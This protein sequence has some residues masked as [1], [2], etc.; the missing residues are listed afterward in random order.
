MR[1]KRASTFV[2]IDEIRTAQR[3]Y[4]PSLDHI[5]V[6]YDVVAAEEAWSELAVAALVGPGGRSVNSPK[7][8]DRSESLLFGDGD[9][10][11]DAPE[12]DDPETLR[13]L[14]R[15]LLTERQ[16]R[17]LDTFRRIDADG[18]GRV[19]LDQLMQALRSLGLHAARGALAELFDVTDSTSPARSIEGGSFKK[20]SPAGGRPR[21]TSEAM[22]P[23]RE[24]GAIE[25]PDLQ[26]AVWRKNRPSQAGSPPSRERQFSSSQSST[27]L[28]Q[29][30]SANRSPSARGFGLAS[31]PL[32]PAAA[33]TSSKPTYSSPLARSQQPEPPPPPEDAGEGAEAAAQAA[34]EGGAPSVLRRLS[35]GLISLTS[36]LLS[37]AA[38]AAC[39]DAEQQPQPQ[40]QPQ[41]PPGAAAASLLTRWWKDE[42][43]DGK[44]ARVA[45]QAAA[46]RS[47]SGAPSSAMV[48]DAALGMGKTIADTDQSDVKR[49]LAAP[50]KL[51]KKAEPVD[52]FDFEAKRAHRRMPYYM[53]GD[54]RFDTAD[55]LRKRIRVLESGRVARAARQFWDALGLAPD[56]T[57]EY[58][59]YERVHS[60]IARVLA[61][62]MPLDEAQQA[63]AEDWS[64]DLRGSG[65]MTFQRYVL[66]IF[67]IADLW[68]D[69][70]N[71][72]DYVILINK[73]FRRVTKPAR[74]QTAAQAALAAATAAADTSVP[75]SRPG[76]ASREGSAPASF[77]SGGG[78]RRS[79]TRIGAALSGSASACVLGTA[80]ATA[81][82]SMAS[83]LGSSGLAPSASAAGLLTGA[84]PNVAARAAWDSACPSHEASPAPAPSRKGSRKPSVEPTQAPTAAA[85]AAAG[86]K[87]RGSS[88]AKGR[89]GSVGGGAPAARK[90]SVGAKPRR[91]SMRRGSAQAVTE[92]PMEEAD[93]DD[94]PAANGADDDE[95][96]D[97]DAD[98]DD[99]ETAAL[100]EGPEA[101][102]GMASDEAA[103]DDELD[104]DDGVGLMEG[105]VSPVNPAVVALRAFRDLDEIRPIGG[106]QARADTASGTKAAR[107][108]RK[109]VAHAHAAKKPPGT[110][111][112]R[113]QFDSAVAFAA[114]LN[115]SSSWG[116]KPAAHRGHAH[117]HHGHAHGSGGAHGAVGGAAGGVA[118]SAVRAA[119]ARRRAA[120]RERKEYRAMALR[121]G[122]AEGASDGEAEAVETRD[123][124]GGASAA[125]AGGAADVDAADEGALSA[126]DELMSPEVWRGRRMC[127]REDLQ[128]SQWA[129]ASGRSGRWSFGE[130]KR[131]D[132]GPLACATEEVAAAAPVAA[133]AAPAAA[134]RPHMALA[135]VEVGRAARD[136]PAAVAVA[137]PPPIRA[138][139]LPAIASS[140]QLPALPSVAPPAAAAPLGPPQ[141]K[142]VQVAK[143]GG[144]RKVKGRYGAVDDEPRKPPKEPPPSPREGAPPPPPP[145]PPHNSPTENVVAPMRSSRT[146]PPVASAPKLPATRVTG[147]AGAIRGGRAVAP[148]AA[149]LQPSASA[150]ELRDSPP[151]PEEAE[152]E[153]EQ[154]AAASRRVST[155]EQSALKSSASVGGFH[156]LRM[157]LQK[158]KSFD[159]KAQP[160]EGTQ[161]GGDAAAP[162]Q[163]ARRR[164]WSRDLR[165]ADSS[166][167]MGARLSRLSLGLS[168]SPLGRLSRRA[169][170]GAFTSRRAGE[171]DEWSQAG[172]ARAEP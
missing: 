125:A 97:G 19:S 99:E 111:S 147:D 28:R 145:P 79:S 143:L 163:R 122:G 22:S 165:Q 43:T 93:A 49:T 35:Q 61:P 152:G 136:E 34:D 120:R 69:S 5:L 42:A 56:A 87:R 90:G 1:F 60:R 32:R 110:S 73:L 62:E 103:G 105:A 156:G 77:K 107:A 9:D 67:E 17:L 47:D 115:G 29:Q 123:D 166:Q 4:K 66:S 70:V 92:T 158:R 81:A 51:A 50:S 15:A 68:T 137:A 109:S 142:G 170:K 114:L 138:A 96:N 94:A 53:R 153:A 135:S 108:A 124:E 150:V 149:P 37:P 101:W 31:S 45:A 171:D 118:G 164:R 106:L 155:G 154:A 36:G 139:P 98:A 24:M 38:S 65:K 40:P 84:A 167:T 129:A 7:S 3:W 6:D 33:A 52:A 72:L 91:G 134:L 25:F 54:D 104:D 8:S 82:A 127:S 121:S 132:V 157:L 57:M 100:D 126:D 58:A 95:A 172:S 75:P 16:E 41:Q 11:D 131:R 30:L 168:N 144:R 23:A 128:I 112:K 64:G 141:A 13:V 76:S 88:S 46:R 161:S 44:A 151:R 27:P 117:A 130:P 59:D 80:A 21:G 86:S 133:A 83:R 160:T 74:P 55:G 116:A 89:K 102:M 10:D 169:S 14:L 148:A 2:R 85:A 12:V 71:E 119:A 113:Q 18:D 162:E 26:R 159:R 140:A 48:V 146:L 78:S 63:C 39:A 20:L